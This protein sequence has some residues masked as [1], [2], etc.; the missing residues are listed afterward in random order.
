MTWKTLTVNTSLEILLNPP[1][2][3]QVE[4]YRLLL[5]PLPFTWF[6]T[7][8]STPGPV[9]LIPFQLEESTDAQLLHCGKVLVLAQLC[10]LALQNTFPSQNSM[11]CTQL[12]WLMCPA[13]L[14]VGKP[15]SVTKKQ[16]GGFF[17]I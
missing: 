9:Y 14:T 15:H 17:W 2:L 10:E 12:G 5:I 3:I 11:N 6:K 16:E 1:T 8:S 7:A 4:H 13:T